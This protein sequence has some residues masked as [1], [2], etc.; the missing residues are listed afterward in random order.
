MGSP[1]RLAKQFCHCLLGTRLVNMVDFILSA[2]SVRSRVSFSLIG[3]SAWWVFPMC[4][5][6]CLL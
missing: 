2:R 3:D 4:L 6:D 5:N 1:L